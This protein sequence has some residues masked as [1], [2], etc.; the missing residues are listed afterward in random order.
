L[1][2]TGI[3]EHLPGARPIASI[4]RDALR[5]LANASIKGT[6]VA[7]QNV[8]AHTSLAQQSLDKAHENRIVRSHKNAHITPLE[9]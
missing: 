6:Y 5:E 2:E 8:D 7:V 3:L 1:T 9:N 4:D